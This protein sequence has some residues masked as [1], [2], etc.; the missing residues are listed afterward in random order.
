MSQ[1]SLGKLK[2]SWV[3]SINS[4]KDEITN[5]KNIVIKILQ[6]ENA[7]M[8]VK[9]EKPENRIA[10]LVSDHNDFAQYGRCRNVVFSGIPGNVS[11]N[12]LERTVN[13]ICWTL[14][15]KLSQG[16]PRRAIELVI[17]LWK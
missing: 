9:Y 5:P 11:G 8:N 13:Q 10:I 1:D 16:M 17:Q 14:K 4:L 3:Q 2:Q 6:G 12:N 7:M 15:L